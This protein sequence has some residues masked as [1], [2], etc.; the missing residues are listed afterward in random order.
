[1]IGRVEDVDRVSMALLGGINTVLAGPRRTGKTTVADAALAICRREDAYVAAVDLFEAPDVASLAHRL[2]IALL[3]N[4]PPL[5]RAIADAV[6]S[7]RSILEALRT[8]ATIRLREDLGADIE[9]ALEVSFAERDPA[10]ALLAALRLAQT[11]AGADGRRVVLFFDEFQDIASRRFGDGE[12]ITRQMRGVLQRSTAVS[13][14]FAGSVEHLMRDLFAPSDRAL[15]QFGSFHEL[16]PITVEQWTVGLRD[17]LRLDDT[18][19][20]DDALERAIALGEMHPRAT[21]LLAQQAHLICIEEVARE[22]DNAM[23]I[24][25]LGRALGAERLRH[26]QQLERIRSIGRHA[27]RMA[28]RVAAGDRPLYADLKPQQA[29]RALTGLRDAGVIDRVDGHGR[30]VLADPLLRIYLASRSP[31]GRLEG[32][33]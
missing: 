20:R 28:V 30:W 27:E 1:M 12:T 21:M 4:R 5:R 31:G 24:Q 14:L 16:A 23:V 3:N 2:T 9:V 8:T 26:E 7:G 19:I 11:L 10:G 17:R 29:S 15:S 6:H 32:R 22:I 18:A 25:A 33:L 13:V